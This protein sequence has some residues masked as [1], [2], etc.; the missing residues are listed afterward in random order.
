MAEAG[1]P[2]PGIPGSQRPVR[3]LDLYVSHVCLTGGG[4]AGRVTSAASCSAAAALPWH[5]A[6]PCRQVKCRE[7]SS[8]QAATARQAC[9]L[10]AVFQ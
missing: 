6:R 1:R 5:D 4:T 9:P 10:P 3:G 2:R 8:R 7:C